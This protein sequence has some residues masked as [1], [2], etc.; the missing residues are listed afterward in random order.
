MTEILFDLGVG[1]SVVACDT[2][3]YFPAAAA[4]LPKIGYQRALSAEGILSFRPDLVIGTEDAGPPIVLDQLRGMKVNLMIHTGD[5]SIPSVL[6]RIRFA[7]KVTGTEKK[8][9]EIV[10]RIEINLEK[11]KRKIPESKKGTAFFVFSRS[12][13]GVQVGGKG[14][15]GAVMIELAGAKN[16]F[17]EIQGYKPLSP[18][19]VYQAKANYIIITEMSLNSLGGESEFWNLPGFR[20]IPPQERP[21]LVSMDD[22]LLLGFGTRIDL[23]VLE[24][25][26]KIYGK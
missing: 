23:A 2:S 5:G 19:M 6:D 3:S 1:D 14:S 8:A 13:G 16:V 26:E 9:N 21:K 12:K 11:A 20:E 10:N 24:L 4:K 18:E 7:G 22:L 17:S 25:Q 15:G